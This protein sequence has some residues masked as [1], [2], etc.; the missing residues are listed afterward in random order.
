MNT[1]RR[2]PT[3]GTVS[4]LVCGIVLHQSLFI[5]TVVAPAA[6][7]AASSLDVDS[8]WRTVCE[9]DAS[10]AQMTRMPRCSSTMSSVSRRQTSCVAVRVSAASEM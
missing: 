3:A 4:R 6:G 8:S 9:Y 10:C 7:G 2:P 5:T 1:T